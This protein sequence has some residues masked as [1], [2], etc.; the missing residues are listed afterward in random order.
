MDLKIYRN[1][2]HP[3]VLIFLF[4]TLFYRNVISQE[5]N[6]ENT[7]GYTSVADFLPDSFKKDG[8][9]SYQKELQQALDTAP[10]N[11]S[12]I[13]FPPMVYL[14]D[15]KGLRLHSNLSLMMRG[16]VFQL[17][18]DCYEDGQ[19]FFGEDL[20]NLQ[21]NGGE[22][23]GCLGK[24]QEGVNIRGIFL[25]GKC[26]NIQI[27]DMYIHDLTSNAIG[28]FASE[29]N[30]A[31]NVRVSDV[32][33]EDACNF[34]GDYLS[35][36]PGPEQGSVREDQ[37]LVAFYFVRDFIVRGCRFLRSRSDGTHFYK[38]KRGQFIENK[39]Y[40]SQMGGYFLEGCEDVTASDNIIL[41]NGSRGVTIERGSRRCLLTANIVSNS[42]REGLWAP[43]S[44]GLVITGNIFDKNGRKPNGAK[45][46]QVWNAN[47][48]INAAHDPSH[49]D[50]RD[51]LVTN[52]IFYTSSAQIAAIRVD[53]DV[54]RD[55]TI[56]NNQMLGENKRVLVEGEKKENITVRDN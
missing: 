2:C 56:K 25:T 40:G 28:I 45:Q 20:V 30:P 43:N 19:A 48:T 9:E 49:T 47:I 31:G 8:S 42:G 13:V 4:C 52:N 27:R 39:V 7:D 21:I 17:K 16:A 6:P 1:Y 50:T 38:S 35:E 5:I 15:E 33:A 37:G 11:G 46:N 24:W 23:A 53:S 51:Y 54:V 32:R 36:K 22:I 12:V 41:D 10:G 26:E 29:A 55:I 34:Y 14:L 44:A 18:N 3:F